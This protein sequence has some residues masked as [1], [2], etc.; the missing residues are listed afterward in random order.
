M[1]LHLV[2]AS[3]L[4]R[5]SLLAAVEAAAAN[6]ADWIQVRDHGAS[7]QELFELASTIVAVARPHGARV[8]VNDR[9]DVALAVGAD[10][11]QLGSRSLPIE[12]VRRI[13]PS[14]RIGASVHDVAGARRA[15]AAGADSLTFGHVFATSSHPGELPRGLTTLAEVVA[16]VTIPVIAIG[17]ITL[18]NVEAVGRT[19]AAGIAVISAILGAVDPAAATAALRRAC[20]HSNL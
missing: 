15:L 10:G 2:T 13:A 14:L 4:D 3:R 12:V 9:V 17:G 5:A 1:L 7:A 18:E 19:G 8:A 11:V 16:A 6:G 20:D